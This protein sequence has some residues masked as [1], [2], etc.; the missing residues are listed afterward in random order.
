MGDDSS[1]MHKSH[2][3]KLRKDD[4]TVS[5]HELDTLSSLPFAFIFLH[6][7]DT[8]DVENCIVPQILEGSPSLLML[9]QYQTTA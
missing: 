8:F 1:L 7:D 2:R 6:I 9:R 4:D 5:P 3:S